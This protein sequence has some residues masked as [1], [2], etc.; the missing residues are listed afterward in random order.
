MGS[1]NTDLV[2]LGGI[3]GCRN[4]SLKSKERKKLYSE[5]LVMF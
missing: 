2:A 3:G 5:L 4:A 1:L